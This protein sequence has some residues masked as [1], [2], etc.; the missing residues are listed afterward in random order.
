MKNTLAYVAMLSMVF[1]FAQRALASDVATK[2]SHCAADQVL[3]DSVC[4]PGATLTTSTSTIC[5]VGYT[6]TVRLVTRTTKRKLFRA[7]DIPWS[8]RG[9][10]EVDHLISLELGGSNALTNLWPESYDITDGA[11]EKDQFENHL[12]KAVCRG[13]M[14]LKEAQSEIANDWLSYYK[15]W[16]HKML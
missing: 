12:H 7:Y 16:K 3:P 13:L 2:T 1:L 5:V 9:N 14:P 8:L 6:K 4:T 10:Y 11:L 15:K